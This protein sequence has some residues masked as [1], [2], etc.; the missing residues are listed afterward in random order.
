MSV[1]NISILLCLTLAA[2][3]SGG[4]EPGA[5]PAALPSTTP[6]VEPTPTSVSR[7]RV[8]RDLG[9]TPGYTATEAADIARRFIHEKVPY[10]FSSGA[11]EPTQEH[12]WDESKYDALV[13]GELTM[14]CGYQADAYRFIMTKLGINS[15]FVWLQGEGYNGAP[16]GSLAHQTAEVFTDGKWWLS[17]PTFDVYWE[18]EERAGA[19]E[20]KKCNSPIPFSA[21]D[22]FVIWKLPYS[23]LDYFYNV[24]YS[25]TIDDDGRLVFPQN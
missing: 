7:E 24:A 15:R 18:C 12:V 11:T 23:Y 6:S 14:Q 22:G 13:K 19:L 2:C 4:S 17:D 1:K 10:D 21:T 25:Y 8:E 16:Q 20:I 5:A 9:L 3:G